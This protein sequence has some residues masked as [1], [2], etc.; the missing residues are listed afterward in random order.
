MEGYTGLVKAR[1]YLMKY[2]EEKEDIEKV[3]I[4]FKFW[5]AFTHRCRGSLEDVFNAHLLDYALDKNA[6]TYRQKLE[7][8]DLA[9][10]S[11]LKYLKS[12]VPIHIGVEV[13]YD[14]IQGNQELPIYLYLKVILS[15][16]LNTSTKLLEL[17][18]EVKGQL[19]DGWGEG[20]EQR[21][22]DL[23]GDVYFPAS[24]CSGRIDHVEDSGYSLS[25]TAYGNEEVTLEMTDHINRGY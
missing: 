16:P 25:C 20:F 14:N 2:N 3:P 21:D 10:Y 1:I 12:L 15:E 17:L 6:F 11:D 9:Q 4:T 13:N 22:L 7:L 24:D 23:S 5:N 18:E 19:S 8:E